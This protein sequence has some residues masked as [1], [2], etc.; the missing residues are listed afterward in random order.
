LPLM[1][2]S[3]PEQSS[4]VLH[5]PLHEDWAFDMSK[6]MF[7]MLKRKI[8]ARKTWFEMWTILIRVE[9][10]VAMLYLHIGLLHMLYIEFKR[11][12][13]THH[14]AHIQLS[15][16]DLK[17]L[18]NKVSF[19]W[20][21]CFDDNIAWLNETWS[22]M[23]TFIYLKVNYNDLDITNNKLHQNKEKNYPLKIWNFMKGFFLG[24]N[25]FDASL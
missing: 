8:Q 3:W 1:Q 16:V 6:G 17:Y 14:G 15:V 24:M 7:M 18:K 10:V 5:G 2:M 9:R 13:C 23:L 22:K 11:L 20:S 25:V 21:I 12:F 19:A 4:R